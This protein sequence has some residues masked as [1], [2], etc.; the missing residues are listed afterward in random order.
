[1]KHSI[2]LYTTKN[3]SVMIPV[4]T[5]ETG[6]IAEEENT[7]RMNSFYTE[8]KASV[9]SYTEGDGFPEGAKYIAKATVTEQSND[10]T[11]KVSL[12][13]R[14]EGKTIS[15]RELSHTWRDGVVIEK[16]IN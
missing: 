2:Q 12:R 15:Q 10:L 9:F 1:M 16:L 8:F 5:C 13:L 6:A 3:T 7:K 14:K 11:V 4:F